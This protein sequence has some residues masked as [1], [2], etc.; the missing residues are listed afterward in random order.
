MQNLNIKMENYKSKFKNELKKRGT[1]N[2]TNNTNA[3]LILTLL[4]AEDNFA[5]ESVILLFKF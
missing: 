4:E 5:F 2:H 3:V 1:T